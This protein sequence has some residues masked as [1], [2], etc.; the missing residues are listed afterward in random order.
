[1][2][3]PKNVKVINLQKE[4]KEQEQRLDPI[5]EISKVRKF[6]SLKIFSINFQLIFFKRNF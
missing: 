6:F 5:I 3:F 1:L 2:F 4:V